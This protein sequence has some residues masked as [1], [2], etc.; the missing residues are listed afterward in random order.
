MRAPQP[1]PTPSRSEN[2]AIVSVCMTRLS[3]PRAEVPTSVDD[4]PMV[5]A[6]LLDIR[7]STYPTAAQDGTIGGRIRNRL[8]MMPPVA[9]A[10]AP[11]PAPAGATP[12]TPAATS[13]GAV[14]GVLPR[15][16]PV[17]DTADGAAA[18]QLGGT[19]SGPMDPAWPTP[20][21]S[22]EPAAP[23]PATPDI[24][25]VPEPRPAAMPN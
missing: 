5:G 22:E 10:R 12:G 23:S 21:G 8:S 2:S 14:S 25:C 24:P 7:G 1:T 3:F 15:A 4:A 9:P 6:Q 20:T 18:V 13:G 11:T 17:G 19:D 16:E